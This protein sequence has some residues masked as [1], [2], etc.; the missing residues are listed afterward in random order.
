MRL[1]LK[2][3]SIIFSYP[4]EDLEELV[5]NREVVRPLLTGEDGEAAALIM[6]FLEKL[7]L[8]RADEEY[9]AVFEMP[10]KCSIY[11]H[12]YL[13]KGKEDMV[14][15]LLLEVKS[16]YKAKQLDMPVEREI[17]TYLPA[18]LEYLALVYDEDPKAARR[19]AKKYLQPWIGELASCLERNR[20]LWSLPAKALKK[21]VDKIAAGR[22][23]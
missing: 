1:T 20:S 18:M 13:L 9:V 3:L 8:E 2:T 22:G 17:P 16:H 5:R 4:S 12:T 7:D 15:Q 6:E 11:A 21:V 14:G 19:F 23:L 10:P